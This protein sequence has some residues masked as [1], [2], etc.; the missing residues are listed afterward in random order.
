MKLKD[1]L[2]AVNFKGTPDDF[3]EILADQFANMFQGWTDEQLYRIP[4][5]AL[6]FCD[7]VRHRLGQRQIDILSVSDTVI[8]GALQNARKRSQ[9]TKPTKRPRKKDDGK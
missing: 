3:V 7:N 6:R 5:E 2:A 8:I 9:I 4:R 1:E